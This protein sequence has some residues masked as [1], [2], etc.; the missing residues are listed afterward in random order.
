MATANGGG[1]TGLN[2]RFGLVLQWQVR[3]GGGGGD[4]RIAGS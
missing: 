4:G 2:E 1:N 3:G